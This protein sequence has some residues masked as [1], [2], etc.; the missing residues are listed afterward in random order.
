M[1]EAEAGD[2]PADER[3]NA[4][5]NGLDIDDPSG[6]PSDAATFQPGGAG[7]PA[8]G[9]EEAAS[10]PPPERPSRS[11]EAVAQHRRGR[12]PAHAPVLSPDAKLAA[13]AA[14]GSMAEG[15]HPCQLRDPRDADRAPRVEKP[16]RGSPVLGRVHTVLAA[17]PAVQRTGEAPVLGQRALPGADRPVKPGGERES[18]DT[19]G[20]RA[21]VDPVADDRRRD[22][23][24]AG[25]PRSEAPR[26]APCIESEE[27]GTSVRVLR[28]PH[29]VARDRRRAVEEAVAHLPAPR[30]LSRGSAD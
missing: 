21:D 8:R 7:W 9:A 20:V 24:R 1:I 22:V 16:P 2:P 18:L 10:P 15:K 25:E 26:S 27:R 5:G 30:H 12:A 13:A 29:D 28:E 4:A 11:G 19:A 14:R 23:G 17:C 6:P 3:D